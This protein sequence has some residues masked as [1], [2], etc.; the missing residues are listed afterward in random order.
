MYLVKLRVGNRLIGQLFEPVNDALLFLGSEMTCFSSRPEGTDR[1]LW[2]RARQRCTCEM[3]TLQLSDWLLSG[4]Y[5][6]MIPVP[7]SSSNYG[8]RCC[9]SRYSTLFNKLNKLHIDECVSPWL[10]VVEWRGLSLGGNVRSPAPA[11]R[12]TPGTEGSNHAPGGLAPNSHSHTHTG[13]H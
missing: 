2:Q 12:D 11:H 7:N 4:L 5:C 6:W 10:R 3:G 1:Q 13:F 8:E 9:L